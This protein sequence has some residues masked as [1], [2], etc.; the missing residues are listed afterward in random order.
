MRKVY[1]VLIFCAIVFNSFGQA[2]IFYEDFQNDLSH[3]KNEFP[4]NSTFDPNWYNFDRDSLVDGSGE[5]RPSAW[6]VD[7][8]FASV[9]SIAI[10][11]GG[12]NLVFASNSWFNTPG[13]VENWLITPAISLTPTHFVQWK[14]AP[15]QTPYKLDGY[16]VLMSTTTNHPDSFNIV[17]F[18]AAQYVGPSNVGG[19]YSDYVFSP[20]GAMVH[21]WDYTST[22][23]SELEFPYDTALNVGVLK[24]HE[25]FF[26]LISDTVYVAFV[27]NSFDD[28]LISIDDIRVDYITSIA[29]NTY[30]NISFQIYP[31]PTS[32]QFNL[33]L[34]GN[35]FNGQVTI[36]DVL[37]RIILE[38]EITQSTTTIDLST[39]AKGLYFVTV[40]DGEKSST[41]KLV[42]E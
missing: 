39:Q 6:Y 19:N 4:P 15:I 20:L 1:F 34:L 9:D 12:S 35:D 18:D 28:N 8:A 30:S 2:T 37:G 10:I 41:L 25:V 27:H 16:K 40:N 23:Y 33:E 11:I 24:Q 38:K 26:G 5:G 14:S 42:V 7:Y 17:L 29:E 22:I 32:G 3:I 21:G 13:S 36:Q 31:N